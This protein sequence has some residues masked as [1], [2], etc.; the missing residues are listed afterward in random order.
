MAEIE[1]EEFFTNYYTP[2]LPSALGGKRKFLDSLTLAR[3]EEGEKWLR[4][5]KAYTRFRPVRRRFNRRP[6]LVSGMSEQVQGDLV[7]VRAHKEDNDEINFLLTL[8]DVFSKKAWVYPLRSKHGMTVARALSSFFSTEKFR[9]MQTDKGKEFLN[10][11]VKRELKRHGIGHFTSENE[12]T[13]ASVVERFNRTL[14]GKIHRH[15]AAKNT[16]R[17]IDALQ[18]FVKSYNNTVHKSTK[19]S[20]NAIT[21]ENHKKPYWYK[22]KKSVLTIGDNVLI[23]MARGSFERGFTPN[24]SQEI[25]TVVDVLDDENPIVYRLKDM[26]GEDIEGTFYPYELQKVNLPDKYE[27]EKII[28]KRRRGRKTEVLVKWQGYPDSFNSWIDE[29]EMV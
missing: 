9:V 10:E 16:W 23:A 2:H 19:M 28:K 26:N 8:I 12:T 27:V 11:N 17:Y 22:K 25:F 29:K 3:R 4:G 5:Q 7:D 1:S 18:D 14:R 21:F 6:T 13:K 15:L 20:P 24:W